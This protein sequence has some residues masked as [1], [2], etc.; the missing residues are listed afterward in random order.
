MKVCSKCKQ[1]KPYTEFS[2]SKSSSGGYMAYCKNCYRVYRADW[3][4][5]KNGKNTERQWLHTTEAGKSLK[6]K[7]HAKYRE[8][9]KRRDYN[10]QRKSKAII[11]GTFSR[12]E[13][14][15]M[16]EFWGNVCLCCGTSNN[17]CADHVIPLAKGGINSIENI[18]P[19]CQ[20]CNLIKNTEY[21]DLRLFWIVFSCF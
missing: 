6:A 21:V 19:I 18:Q 9:G 14:A 12:L 11:T 15:R 13:F 8:S 1:E 16:K 7:K 3:R 4:L 17:L 10:R 20:P 2:K 5:H